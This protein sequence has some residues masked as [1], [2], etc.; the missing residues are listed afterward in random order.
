MENIE[1]VTRLEIW[2]RDFNLSQKDNLDELPDRHAVFGIFGIV[3][4]EP[5]NC[6]YVG[7]TD[8]LRQSV[9]QLFQNPE[10][11]GMKKFMQGPWIQMLSYQLFDDTSVEGR[12]AIATRWKQQYRPDI[13]DDGEYPGYY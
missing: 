3:N 12:M 2:H 10:G 6:R 11:Q 1:S 4:D 13:D 8:N 5:V 9:K 7:E